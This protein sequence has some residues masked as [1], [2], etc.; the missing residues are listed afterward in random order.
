M[1]RLRPLKFILYGMFVTTLGA[2]M[3]YD[4]DLSALGLPALTTATGINQRPRTTVDSTEFDARSDVAHFYCGL[5][6]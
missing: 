2:N 6:R 5:L 1:N 3:S 4:Q